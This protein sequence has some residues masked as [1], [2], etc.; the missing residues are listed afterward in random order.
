[1]NKIKK[2]ILRLYLEIKFLI[3]RKRL[4]NRDF[5][6][7]CNNC[8]GGSLYQ[9]L[10]LEYKTPFVG[11]FLFGK[12]YMNLL[13]NLN[14]NM[15]L[16][17]KHLPFE[18]SKYHQKIKEKPKY[19][20]GVLG[21][22]GIE[23]HF[24]HYKNWE[25][26]YNKWNRRKLRININNLLIVCSDKDIESHMLNKNIKDFKNLPFKNKIFFS[27]K[28]KISGSIYFPEIKQKNEYG[29]WLYRKYIN[30]IDY[31]NNMQ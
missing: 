8:W 15:K 19:P 13:K 18:N 3:Q 10:K 30:I 17:L 31:L 29:K 27:G 2:N 20:I 16:E 25:E 21:K 11:L 28:K 26:A 5:S 12:C 9:S 6:I 22:S 23:I 1:M 7:I 14:K 24:L 4:K